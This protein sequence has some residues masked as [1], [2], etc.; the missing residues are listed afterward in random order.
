MPAPPPRDVV[1][2]LRSRVPL[3]DPDDGP[4]IFPMRHVPVCGGFSVT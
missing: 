1:E 4:W 3:G 2:P